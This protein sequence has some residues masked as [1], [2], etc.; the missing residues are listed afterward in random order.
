MSGNWPDYLLDEIRARADIVEVI[1]DYVVLSKKGRNYLGLCP[2]H[3]EKTPSFTVAPDKQMFYCFGCQTGGNVF[4]FLTKKENI[5][6]GEAVKFLAEKTGVNLPQ[7][8]LDPQEQAKQKQLERIAQINK[9]SK[10]FYHEYLLSKPEAQAARDYLARRGIN[11]KV[12][13]EFQLGFAPEGWSGLTSFLQAR[14]FSL[15]EMADAGVVTPKE[16]GGGYDR[17]R[18]RIIFPIVNVRGQVIGFG[19][20]VLDDSL[21]KYL[22][23]PETPFFSKRH[24]LYGIDL[25]HK[26]MREKGETLVVEGYMDVIAAHQSGFDNAVASLGTALTRD[27]GKLILR[28]TQKVVLAYDSDGAGVSAAFKGAE[29]LRALGCNVKILTVPAGK[30]PDEFLRSHRPEEF[31]LLT[32]NA[33]GIVPYKLAHLTRERPTA[34]INAKVEIVNS[35]ADDLLKTESL[36]ERGGYIQLIAKTL[37]ITEE[38]IYAELERISSKARKTRVFPDKSRLN[39][40]TNNGLAH[41]EFGNPGRESDVDAALKIVSSQVLRAENLLLRLMLDEPQVIAL[42]HENLGWDGFR[43]PVHSKALVLIKEMWLKGNWDPATLAAMVNDQELE[44]FFARLALADPGVS[45]PL[46]AAG[47]CIKVIKND[48]I[49]EKINKLQEQARLMQNNGDV[50]NAMKLLQQINQL[51]RQPA[52]DLPR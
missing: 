24:N 31:A 4:T 8:E 21:P 49:K 23:T 33:P 12:L 39:S 43:D 35:L 50:E 40:H 51:I 13:E 15:K 27:Q 36:I 18:N 25:A 5:S 19:G 11:H 30:D 29:I 6:F 9:A 52:S 38:V 46:K 17:F 34:N 42:V 2:F 32:E 14:G 47:D 41:S 26:N 22:N 7:V 10:D 37:G 45:S 1:S 3:H 16:D 28:Y 44:S 48:Q 20:R